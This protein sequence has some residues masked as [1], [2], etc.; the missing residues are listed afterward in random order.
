MFMVLVGSEGTRFITFENTTPPEAA[1]KPDL[2]AVGNGDLSVG[3]VATSGE[4]GHAIQPQP[5]A[6]KW[7]GLS[8]NNRPCDR[9]ICRAPACHGRPGW[10]RH[11]RVIHPPTG[12]RQVSQCP[13]H[14][15]K[16]GSRLPSAGAAGSATL[17]LIPL[18]D[19]GSCVGINDVMWPTAFEPGILQFVIDVPAV[20][21]QHKLNPVQGQVPVHSCCIRLGNGQ[22]LVASKAH[23]TVS[24]S[25]LSSEGGD[26][27][28]A[29]NQDHR[30]AR[31]GAKQVPLYE[32]RHRRG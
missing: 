15:Q 20:V 1:S 4:Q 29:G 30:S 13:C 2:G 11:K 6:G 16:P 17:L 8:P 9:R 18:G 19:N 32:C 5:G 26:L 28:R 7:H 24:H 27:V 21:F 12:K 3:P 25:L 22:Y 31:P 14:S 10:A 23:H